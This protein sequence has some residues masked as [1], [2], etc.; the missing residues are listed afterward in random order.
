MVVLLVLWYGSMK[1][2]DN[3]TDEQ[4]QRNNK[5]FY[6][7]RNLELMPYKIQQLDNT[8]SVYSYYNPLLSPVTST[9]F[10]EVKN[11]PHPAD[12]PCPIE[13]IQAFCG[14]IRSGMQ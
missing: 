1:N 9:E 8:F 10:Y 14:E 13:L 5:V 2:Q 3:D 4:E 7:Q 12:H 6:S 11:L